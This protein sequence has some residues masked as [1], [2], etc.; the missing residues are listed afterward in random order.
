MGEKVLAQKSRAACDQ[1]MHHDDVCR[2]G[3][4]ST[5]RFISSSGALPSSIGRVEG[6]FLPIRDDDDAQRRRLR[7]ASHS[8]HLSLAHSDTNLQPF[9]RHVCRARLD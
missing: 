4:L 6:F 9:F 7:G 5:R 1:Y 8:S 3:P 2:V